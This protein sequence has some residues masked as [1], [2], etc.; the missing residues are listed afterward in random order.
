MQPHKPEWRA[1]QVL[2]A[3]REAPLAAIGRAA[4]RRTTIETYTAEGLPL[5]VLKEIVKR[6]EYPSVGPLLNRPRS[7]LAAAACLLRSAASRFCLL[8]QPPITGLAARDARGKGDVDDG[9]LNGRA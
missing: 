6:I 5:E 8:G 7:N 9:V 1:N 3:A 4:L 2:V